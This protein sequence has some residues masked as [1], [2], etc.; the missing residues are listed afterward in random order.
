MARGVLDG[1]VDIGAY[2]RCRY[3]LSGDGLVSVE[4]ILAL[5][6][7]WATDP[8]G[9]PDFDDSGDVGIDDFLELL[10]NWTGCD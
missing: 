2:E 3:D 8:G 6:A 5:L 7:A 1:T 9:P 10:A 4:D